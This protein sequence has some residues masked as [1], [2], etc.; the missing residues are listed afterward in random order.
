MKTQKPTPIPK[1]ASA[2]PK[3]LT[4]PQPD[5]N[6]TVVPHPLEG[7]ELRNYIAHCFS[8]MLFKALEMPHYEINDM[9]EMQFEALMR[10]V[11]EEE[12]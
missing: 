10:S 11:L 2:E 9:G 5:R 6:I 4:F 12:E 1:R 3:P 7:V 8:R